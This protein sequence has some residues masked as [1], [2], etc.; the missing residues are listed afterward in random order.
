MQDSIQFKMKAE[1]GTG[2]LR[3]QFEDADGGTG[4]AGINFTPIG[5]NEWHDYI[6]ALRD[7]VDF[8]GTGFDTSTVN[9]FQ[10]LAE[11]T[12]SGKVLYIDDLW[13]GDPIIDIIPPAPP[14]NLSV[15]TDNYVNLLN[16][17]DSANEDG[18]TY[19]VY[20]SL[21]PIDSL[22]GPEIEIVERG[23]GIAEN[24]GAVLN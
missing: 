7:F 13:T 20:W 10:W 12:G 6:F 22:T 16:W 1:E 3:L 9:V 19:N 24:T 14:T 18:E 11:G 15:L 21:T 2:L 17:L 23:R 4:H 5:D 8:D